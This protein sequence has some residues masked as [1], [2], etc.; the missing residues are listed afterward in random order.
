[1]LKQ[2]D[3]DSIKPMNMVARQGTKYSEKQIKLKKLRGHKMSYR[4]AETQ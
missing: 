4:I 3:L 2:V 1:M